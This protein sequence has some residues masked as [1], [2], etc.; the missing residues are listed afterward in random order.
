MGLS[1]E[2]PARDV[3]GRRLAPGYRALSIALPAR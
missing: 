1:P 2:D 3:A